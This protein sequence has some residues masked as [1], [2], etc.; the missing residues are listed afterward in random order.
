MH[1][2]GE[3][4]SLRAE[5][6]WQKFIRLKPN[7]ALSHCLTLPWPQPKSECLYMWFLLRGNDP[8]EN[9]LDTVKMGP[10]WSY[11]ISK[12]RSP[13]HTTGK[14]GWYKQAL[15]SNFNCTGSLLITAKEK[16]TPKTKDTGKVT[17]DQDAEI[18]AFLSKVTFFVWEFNFVLLPLVSPDNE[19]A[20]I[21]CMDPEVCWLCWTFSVSVVR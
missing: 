5:I 18:I 7:W 9:Q 15:L 12:M 10:R 21:P 20:T 16:V 6:W 13:V 11:I 1:G 14:I 2:K 4:V 17:K 19:L 8:I 3:W